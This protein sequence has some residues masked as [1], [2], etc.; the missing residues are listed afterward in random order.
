MYLGYLLL[1]KNIR[2]PVLFISYL[3]DVSWSVA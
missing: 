3:L 1:L 2:R